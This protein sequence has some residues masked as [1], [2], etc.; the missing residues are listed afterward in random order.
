MSILFAL[1][2]FC[3][4]IKKV[5][6]WKWTE[7]LFI[8]RSIEL[9]KLSNCDDILLMNCE[10]LYNLLCVHFDYLSTMIIK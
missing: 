9:L 1:K 3:W 10:L 4:V 6:Q 8:E 5:K 7:A 2:K